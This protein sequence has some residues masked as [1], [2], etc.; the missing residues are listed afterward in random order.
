MMSL[1]VERV[2]HVGTAEMVARVPVTIRQNKKIRKLKDK[3]PFLK[4]C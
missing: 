1:Q 4:L 2:D 3:L